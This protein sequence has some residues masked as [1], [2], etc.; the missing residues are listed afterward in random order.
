M[1]AV[2]IPAGFSQVTLRYVAHYHVAG[3]NLSAEV[4]NNFSDG[5]ML[6][7][8]LVVGMALLRK[9]PQVSS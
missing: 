5:A 7:A 8:W 1:R 6:A 4:V 2:A 3:R 9:K